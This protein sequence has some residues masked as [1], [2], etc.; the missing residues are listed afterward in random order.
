MAVRDRPD[1]VLRAERGVAAEEHLRIGGRHGRGV[2]LGH[3]PLVELDA[4]IALDPGKC[5][6]L[7]DGDQHVVAGKVLVRLA[8]RHQIAAAF[9]VAHRFDLFEDDA[10]ELAVLVGEFLRHHDN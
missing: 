3:V 7:A 9:G 8:G 1:D 4:A 10:G 2:D 5:I 6:F